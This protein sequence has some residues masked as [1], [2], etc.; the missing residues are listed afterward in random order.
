MPAIR[1]FNLKEEVIEAEAE[2]SL[3][4]KYKQYYKIYVIVEVEVTTY[5]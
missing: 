3:K 2:P 4:V 1:K 5:N